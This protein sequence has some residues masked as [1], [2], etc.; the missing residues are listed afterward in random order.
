MGTPTSVKCTAAAADDACPQRCCPLPRRFFLKDG[1]MTDALS[2]P[3]VVPADVAAAN[4]A[5][6]FDTLPWHLQLPMMAWAMQR[7]GVELPLTARPHQA[8]YRYHQS[9]SAC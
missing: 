6:T 9:S 1:F 2:G 3:G 8:L 5:W 7:A 4:N